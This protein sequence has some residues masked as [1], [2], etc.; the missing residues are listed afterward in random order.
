MRSPL[1]AMHGIRPHFALLQATPGWGVSTEAPHDF[2]TTSEEIITNIDKVQ[3]AL[4]SMHKEME[5]LQN[6]EQQMF[7]L[8]YL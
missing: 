4:Y 5:Q 2:G 3:E 7:S 8:T 1:E 6:L